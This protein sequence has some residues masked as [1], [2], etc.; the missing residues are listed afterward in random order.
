MVDRRKVL[1]HRFRRSKKPTPQSQ[2]FP[3][4]ELPLEIRIIIYKYAIANDALKPTRRRLPSLLHTNLQITREIYKYCALFALYDVKFPKISQTRL[5]RLP[6]YYLLPYLVY[7]APQAIA[8]LVLNRQLKHIL[9][10]AQRFAAHNDRKGLETY[11]RTR[12]VCCN[13]LRQRRRSSGCWSCRDIVAH[14]GWQE[15]WT[16]YGYGS[17]IKHY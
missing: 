16:R 7:K 4:L 12:C 5:S 6:G 13:G 10:G 2:I 17:L 11:I 3:F 15:M 9:R 1:V 8:L 14:E